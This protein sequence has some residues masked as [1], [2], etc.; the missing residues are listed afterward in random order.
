[1]TLSYSPIENYGQV[2]S[3]IF[4]SMW[5]L[6][7]MV[8]EGVAF[9]LMRKGLGWNAAQE[10]IIRVIPWGIIVFIC[11][12]V[13]YT[14]YTLSPKLSLLTELLWQT[15]L[16]KFYFCL[17]VLPW[18]KFFRRPAAIFYG[19]FWFFFRIISIISFILFYQDKVSFAT[20]KCMYA[21]G[22]VCVYFLFEPFL[23]YYTLLQD[24]RWWQG[25]GNSNK[26]SGN[27]PNAEIVSPL[28]GADLNV[29]SAQFLAETVDFM[30]KDEVKLL[31]FAYI[32]LQRNKPL[33]SGSFSK[34][35]RGTY[36]DK[37]CAIKLVFT[38]DITED[39]INR[40]AAEVNILSQI[41][42]PNVVHIFGVSV[43]PPSVCIVLELCQYGSLADVIK[44]NAVDSK[45]SVQAK[46]VLSLFDRYF[47]AVGC[48]RGLKA[49]HDH[50]A[51]L[52]HRDIKSFNFLVDGQLNAKIADLELGVTKSERIKEI[53]AVINLASPISP[54]TDDLNNCKIGEDSLLANW[55]APEF[56]S[57]GVYTQASDIYSM[58]LVLWEMLTGCVPFSDTWR[59][60]DIQQRVSCIFD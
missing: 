38:L 47:L 1:M 46:A 57:S 15:I 29:K 5:A 48:L 22:N 32:H 36:R 28:S 42:H 9:M 18:K 14:I 26:A 30:V 20:G 11:K 51:E 49:L 31:N 60:R 56:I 59:Q 23:V 45:P 34:V 3:I 41:K 43:L 53:P 7:H 33:G 10:V 13:G 50:D 35:Y 40:I 21:F 6:E 16:L 54:T 8:V 25:L 58:S 2:T 27:Q 4:S 37:E 17:W 39:T 24:S 55:A 44:G 12:Y 52:C 19:Q